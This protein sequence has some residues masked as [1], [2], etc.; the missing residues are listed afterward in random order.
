MNKF[1]FLWSTFSFS[2]LLASPSTLCFKFP[3]R[4]SCSG[5]RRLD[6]RPTVRCCGWS[7]T[8]RSANVI[9]C[10]AEAASKSDTSWSWINQKYQA[11]NCLPEGI[12]KI[13][14]ISFKRSPNYINQN[15]RA[16]EEDRP[17]LHPRIASNR[18]RRR[19]RG[20]SKQ[21]FQNVTARHGVKY[22]TPGAN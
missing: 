9:V 21:I 16:K 4:F 18:I 10:H 5:R 22:Y 20:S 3:F 14:W 11:T 13:G 7:N 2:F 8:H 17:S 6:S 12:E 19:F 15:K 1:V